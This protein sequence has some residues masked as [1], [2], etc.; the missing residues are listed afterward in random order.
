MSGRLP[1]P[2]DLIIAAVAGLPVIALLAMALTSSS[3][4]GGLGARMLPVA[5]RDTGLLLLTVGVATAVIGFV[6]AWLVAHFDFPGRRIA[7]WAF[8][9][10]LAIPTYLSAYAWVEVLEFTGPV[11]GALRALT[12][13]ETLRDYWFPTIR[14]L[15][16][17][18]FV[19]S[20]VL[21][22]YV[23]LTCRAYFFM[24]SGA[25]TAAARTLG[26]SPWRTFMTVVLPLSRPAVIVGV[27]LAL[28]EAM[29]DI[30]AVEFFG[31]N[32][33]TAVV[34]ATWINQS[35]LPGAAQLALTL[36]LVVAGL[37]WLEQYARRRRSYLMPRDSRTPPP[38]VALDGSGTALAVVFAVGVI[39]LGFGVPFGELAVGALEQLSRTG[40]PEAVWSALAQTVGLAL[41]G[42]LICLGFGYLTAHRLNA[43]KGAASRS[44][45]RLATLGYALPGTVLAIGLLV[46]LG[47][48]DGAINGV[49][50]GLFGVGVGLV[51]TGSA[52]ALVYAYAVRFLTV[53][54]SSLLTGMGRRGEHLLDAARVLGA[55]RWTLIWRIDLPTLRPALIGAATLV[56]VECIK[57]LP[58]T[59]LLRP[60]GIETLSTFVYQQAKAELFPAA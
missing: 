11:Q 6:A 5:L 3:G 43:A 60:L 20:L 14:S 8:M 30:G 41:A 34:Y 18:A 40:V 51:F 31:V 42:A 28:L 17:A 52:V 49:T 36:V 10:P 32:S 50:R 27:T 1:K 33:L 56:F 47:A 7:E 46:P 48:L 15:G 13:A 58:A 55:S 26:A 45:L 16:G 44:L 57:E 2:A 12:G 23:Y 21:Y 37:I 19:M 25:M 35:N 38:R 54:H 24:Q 53:S 22:P 59:L 4:T 9:L 29:N 39:G